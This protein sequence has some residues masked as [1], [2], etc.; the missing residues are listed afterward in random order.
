MGQAPFAAHLEDA[1]CGCCTLAPTVGRLP[2]Q[3]PLRCVRFAR[4]KGG[5]FWPLYLIEVDYSWWRMTRVLHRFQGWEQ[6]LRLF[7]GDR[8]ECL[9]EQPPGQEMAI[10]FY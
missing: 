5:R 4:P 2:R 8:E 10:I 3:L 9:E 1:T 7:P 6:G